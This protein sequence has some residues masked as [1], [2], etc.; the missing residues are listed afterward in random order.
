MF[1]CKLKLV[2]DICKKWTYKKFMRKNLYLD[3]TIK[4]KFKNENK[5]CYDNPCVICDFDLGTAKVYGADS[6]K[7]HHFL[8]NIF[9]DLK[10]CQ[11]MQ[12]LES[13]YDFFQKFMWILASLIT[14]KYTDQTDFENI[15]NPIM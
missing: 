14:K 3:L 8:I 15:D 13:Y 2:V 10:S 5:I 12:K 7:E 11:S 1:C 6:N 9:T 4:T